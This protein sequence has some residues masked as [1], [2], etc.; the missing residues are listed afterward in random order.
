MYIMRQKI[1]RALL[2]IYRALLRWCRACLWWYRALLQC[3]RA[4]L[5][6]H[7]LSHNTSSSC[8]PGLVCNASGLICSGVEHF[9]TSTHD[10][11]AARQHCILYT[12][13]CIYFYS[14]ASCVW[15]TSMYLMCKKLNTMHYTETGELHLA[16]NTL[17]H[18]TTSC[19]TLQPIATHLNT[20]QHTATRK[21]HIATHCNTLHQITT[22]DFEFHKGAHCGRHAP[23][24]Y[25]KLQH[26]AI[27]C[28]ALQ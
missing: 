28:N 11:S 25:T 15:W 1:Y 20:L 7:S 5:H 22:G 10:F 13:R 6:E 16:G 18:T 27:H 17:Q 14:T 19:Y 2:Q 23:T 8:T 12:C 26:T 4:L 9:W 3:H 21:L 24:H